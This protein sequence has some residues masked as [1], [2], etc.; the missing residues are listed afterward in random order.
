SPAFSRVRDSGTEAR[1]PIVDVLRTY[2]KNV[3]LGVGSR[4]GIDAAFYIV[5]FYSLTHVATNLGLSQNVALIAVSIA[6]LIEIFTIPFFAGLSDRYGR[7]PLLIA[8]AAFMG[9]WIFPFFG[10]LN[11]ENTILIVVALVAGLSVGHAAVYGVQ[12]SFY[13][14]LFGTRVRYS[15]ASFAYQISGIFGGALAPIIAAILY[16]VG[17]TT[18]IS[19]YIAALCALSVLCYVLAAETYRKDI[20]EKDPEERRLVAEQG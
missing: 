17:G 9:I 13:A 16:P 7:R 8:G 5:A 10:L 1:A 18:L 6:A 3:A 15:G 14:E 11:T 19:I 12:A 20:Y 2:P 4:I